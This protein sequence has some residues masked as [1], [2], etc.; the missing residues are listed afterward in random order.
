[1]TDKH[2]YILYNI[3]KHLYKQ[4]LLMRLFSEIVHT[5]VFI[6]LSLSKVGVLYIK[7]VEEEEKEK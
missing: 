3:L 5:V 4:S 2:T 1:M 7:T 6:R